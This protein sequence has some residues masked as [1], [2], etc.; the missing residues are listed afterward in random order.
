MYEERLSLEWLKSI[1]K[2]T[3]KNI[4]SIVF[5]GLSGAIRKVLE[6]RGAHHV[7]NDITILYPL[8]RPGHPG[9]LTNHV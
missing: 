9:T 3:G 5:A 6:E 4:T 8:P 2:S 1:S 7:A